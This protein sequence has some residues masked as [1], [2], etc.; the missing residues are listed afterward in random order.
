MS[1][2]EYVI[3]VNEDDKQIGTAEKIAAHRQ[4]QLHR[5]FS[6]FV[7]RDHNGQQETL[8]QQRASDKYHCPDLWTNSCCSHPRPN[9]DVVLAGERRLREELGVITPLRDVGKFT[10]N[11]HFSNGL[12][13]HEVD[14]VLIGTVPA[15]VEVIPDPQEVQAYRWVTIADLRKE[16]EKQPE[17]FTPWLILAIDLLATI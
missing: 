10:Y 12:S 17:S 16:I 11:A 13:E 2:T 4:N 15:D 5:A 8:L 1:A 9:E 6:V 7:F 3:L 14:H